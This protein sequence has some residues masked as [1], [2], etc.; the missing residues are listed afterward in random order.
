MF[1]VIVFGATGFTGKLVCEYIVKNYQQKDL[2]W[3]IAGRSQNKLNALLEDL[4]VTENEVG[5]LLV[6]ADDKDSLA[7]M[8]QSTNVLL[9]TVGPYGQYGSDVV[10]ACVDNGTDYCDLC[11]EVSW[12][13]EMI[14]LYQTQA[15]ESG[16]RIVHSCGFD[17][18]PSDM[19]VL[20]SQQVAQEVLGRNLEKIRLYVQKIKGGVSGGTVHSMMNEVKRARENSKHAKALRNP[21]ALNPD[22]TFSGPDGA[23]LTQVKF[24]STLSKWVAPFVMAVINTRIVRRSNALSDY[25]YGENFQYS[26]V[27][28][29]GT[30]FSQ[31]AAAR[32]MN[33]GLGMM[34][35]TMAF[36]WGR[37]LLS[38]LV[39]PKPGQGPK[40][41]P[42]DP[43]MYDLLLLG[44]T[45]SGDELKV[46]VT[47]DSDPGYGS[48]SKMLAEAAICLAKDNPITKGG[49]W[50]PAT[51]L[52]DSYL[53][54]LQEK[55]GLSFTAIMDEHS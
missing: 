8:A 43:G 25:A 20:Y 38:N 23:D 6:D 32:A 14:D 39:L 11:G 35:V 46:Q 30:K 36:G 16:A 31:R 48:T 1:D 19:G 53:N 21:Y 10:Q 27:T 34:V 7:G 17:S 49:F 47:G 22:P 33:V 3:A 51:A 28:A 54:R 40:V 18:V 12:M 2:N 9:T 13:R 55:A 42:N 41:D 15:E 44:K 50:T 5:T 52:G 45:D 29:L 37:S 4:G 26:E 24:D